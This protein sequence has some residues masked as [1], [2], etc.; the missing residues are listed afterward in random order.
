[1]E[2]AGKERKLAKELVVKMLKTNK[3]LTLVSVKTTLMGREGAAP[4]KVE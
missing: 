3:S 1:M 2:G 4:G